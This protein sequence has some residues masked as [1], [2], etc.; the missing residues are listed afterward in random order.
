VIGLDT[1]FLVRYIAQ[2][3]PVQSPLAEQL[4]EKQCSP[5]HPGFVTLITLIELV[6][7]SESCYEA[8]KEYVIELLR[9]LLS[10]RQLLVQDCEIAWQALRLFEKGQADFADCVVERIARAKGCEQVVTFDKMAAKA[11]MKLLR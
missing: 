1:N 2:D 5:E 6:W 7:V 10:T 8:R 11:G 9:R 4:I 3:D